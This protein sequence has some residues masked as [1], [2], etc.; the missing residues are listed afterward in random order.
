MTERPQI[1]WSPGQAA[2]IDVDGTLV[3]TNYHH[4]VAWQIAFDR[5]G[6]LVPTS[7]LHRHVGMGG[8]QFVPA[9]AG[10]EARGDARRRG[11][12]APRRDL[13]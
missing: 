8:D 11:A 12:R 6:A 9:V 7:V 1:S 3:D 13:P 5:V 2:V 4:V 10:D